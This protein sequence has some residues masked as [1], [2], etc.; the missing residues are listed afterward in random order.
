MKY[1]VE[2]GPKSLTGTIVKSSRGLCYPGLIQVFRF[3][4]SVCTAGVVNYDSHNIMVIKDVVNR[5]LEVVE[6]VSAKL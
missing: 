2:A 4:K 6:L 3:C 1:K 5:M